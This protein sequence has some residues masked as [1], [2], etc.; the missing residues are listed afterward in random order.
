M[1]SS[2][3][4]DQG[5][6]SLS[7]QCRQIL[8]CLP[9]AAICWDDKGRI[10]EVNSAAVTLLRYEDPQRLKA[11]KIVDLCP[12]LAEVFS[13][14]RERFRRRV[15]LRC[16]DGSLV[17]VELQ[18]RLFPREAQAMA[19]LCPDPFDRLLESTIWKALIDSIHLGVLIT[20]GQ[21]RLIRVNS[22]GA[23]LLGLKG[24]PGVDLFELLGLKRE[25]YRR[26]IHSDGQF[27]RLKI[28][29]HD[30]ELWIELSLRPFKI[31]KRDYLAWLINDVTEQVSL[32]DALHHSHKFLQNVF[33]AIN[34]GLSV[35]DRELNILGVNAAM[36]RWYG[37]A[38]EIVGKKCYEIY[39]RRKEPCPDCPSL[40]AMKT[41]QTHRKIVPYPSYDNPRGWI[42]LSSYPLKD[43][44]GRIIGVIE[45][46]KDISE[47][48]KAQDEL[49]TEKERL[50]TIL[51]GIADGVIS[52]DGEG[53]IVFINPAAQKILEADEKVL[54]QSFGR[55]LRLD[56]ADDAVVAGLFEVLKG[57]RDTFEVEVMPVV[58]DEPTEKLLT[59]RAAALKDQT[60][61]AGMVLVFR[62]ITEKKRIEEE[63]A[64]AER[65]EALGI[66]S[67]GIAHDF[68][69]I[70]TALAGNLSLAALKIPE[71]SPA[72]DYLKGA[73]KALDQAKG[74]TTQLQTFSQG[75]L[76]LKKA[77][78]ID[79][80]LRETV[81]FTLRGSNVSPEFDLAPDLFPAEVD[82]GQIHQ[83]IQNIVINAD[84][85]MPHGG[86]LR[87]RAE[88][89]ISDGE[90]GLTAGPYI[91][92]TFEDEGVGIPENIIDRIFDP[93]FS[94]K[95]KGS[96]LGLA[97]A[98]SIVK[99]HGGTITVESTLGHG[100]VFTVYL[101]ALSERAEDISSTPDDFGPGSLGKGFKKA[102]ILLMD[103]DQDVR[104][105][106]S[107]MLTDLGYEVVVAPEGHKALSLYRE[108]LETGEPFDLVIMDL[109]IPGGMGGREAVK[110]LLSFDPS[111]RVIVSSGYSNDD[112]MANYQ[113]YGFSGVLPKPFK[114]SELKSV[115]ERLLEG[116]P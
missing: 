112:V 75:G 99:R 44:A 76:P 37:R 73:L 5:S 86:R 19:F 93:Y 95:Q 111:A 71:G 53:K 103:D 92:L 1:L 69:N 4:G 87:I 116:N 66:L 22:L 98:Y 47:L 106:A 79:E 64:R 83:V 107:Q 60:R 94:T 81:V 85:A 13:R 21:G 14:S 32:S 104:Q 11:T 45:Y 9:L 88:N 49:L 68:N 23:H 57:K 27:L 59:L 80:L 67:G 101:P 43:E 50:A 36:E 70:L 7:L 24:E 102:R 25:D 97:S 6:I 109:T 3:Q 39:Q 2:F 48:K 91:K 33:D 77:V 29:P 100:S 38:E 17:K 28:A 55:I 51:E 15:V 89:Y 46:C 18:G 72:Q 82:P 90:E 30:M 56:E 12:H 110:E 8:D 74:L 40:E 35:L 54:G 61:R 115:L 105:V 41:G 62:D 52:T 113:K 42:D 108:A 78:S 20:D 84:Q 63:L 65:L 10:L 114:L 16:R 31:G 26:L 58:L 96:G 34:D